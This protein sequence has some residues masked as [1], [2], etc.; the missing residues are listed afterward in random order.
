MKKIEYYGK[1]FDKN[2][3]LFKCPI[4]GS[5]F[6]FWD[7]SLSCSLGHSFDLSAKG[8]VNLLYPP[9]KQGSIYSSKLWASREAVFG[10]GFF[11]PL[12]KETA[13]IIKRNGFH[14]FALAD[15]GCGEGSF[16]CEIA[17]RTEPK[18]TIGIDI[19][20]EAINKAISKPN[21]SAVWI[22]A[23][24]AALPFCDNSLDVAITM[25]SPSNYAECR[26]VV[27][28]GG[29]VIKIIPGKNYLSELRRAIFVDEPRTDYSNEKT[30]TLFRDT[31]TADE[32]YISYFFKTEPEM[33]KNIFAM[34][35]LSSKR[36]YP[37]SAL[38]AASGVS[39][40][41]KILYSVL[42]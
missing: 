29:L 28:K 39:V 6:S 16:L 26:R 2:I 35:P 20:K 15:L 13:N 30:E 32:K 14:N 1:I 36:K 24:T 11:E 31:F 34:T 25:L 4:C 40:E 37:E 23:N 12:I 38:K 10:A 8:S 7:K 41:F 19:S 33:L 42:C 22:V 9:K 21:L 27:K 5:A 18:T 3:N 17:A